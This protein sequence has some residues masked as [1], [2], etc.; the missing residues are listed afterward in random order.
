[1][2]MRIGRRHKALECYC[3]LAEAYNGLYQLTGIESQCSPGDGRDD[4][5]VLRY[6]CRR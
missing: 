4:R 3:N 6:R 5:W 2:M 1:M